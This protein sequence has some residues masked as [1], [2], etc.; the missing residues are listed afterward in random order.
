MSV[1]LGRN[2]RWERERERE[3]GRGG[4]GGEEGGRE[5]YWYAASRA[6]VTPDHPEDKTLYPASSEGE[7]R[8]HAALNT[9]L[10][11][12]KPDS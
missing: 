3:R 1:T 10:W 4:R 8:N 12:G 5:P 6:P 11:V 7:D 2:S 9:P